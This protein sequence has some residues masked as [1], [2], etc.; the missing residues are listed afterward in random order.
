[1]Q[2][3]NH[4]S[5]NYYDGKSYIW[6]GINDIDYLR[7][8]ILCINMNFMSSSCFSQVYFSLI[9]HFRINGPDQIYDYVVL[10]ILPYHSYYPS[11]CIRHFIPAGDIFYF[12]Y[13]PFLYLSIVGLSTLLAIKYNNKIC[14]FGNIG[15]FNHL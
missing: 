15:W 2:S 13:G 12:L 1:M 8:W 3:L 5:K 10:G 11:V 7:W 14:Y 6:K 4:F 9:K